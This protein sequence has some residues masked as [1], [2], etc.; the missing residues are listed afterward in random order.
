SAHAPLSFF[1]SKPRGGKSPRLTSSSLR[2]AG[3]SAPLTPSYPRC[4]PISGRKQ[5]PAKRETVTA[6][7]S[8]ARLNRY[9]ASREI[10]GSNETSQI[11]RVSGGGGICGGYY[12]SAGARTNSQG[13]QRSRRTQL[14]RQRRPERVFCSRQQRQLERVRRRYVSGDRRGHLQRCQQGRIRSSGRQPPIW[15]PSERRNRRPVTQ[16]H[17]DDVA[18]SRSRADLCGDELLRRPG[19]PHSQVHEQGN[20]A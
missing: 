19:L 9:D 15:S 14:R 7:P 2:K 18:G 4:S 11:F 8:I 10:R 1:A 3:T 5:K 12:C 20:R 13:R 16:H 6:S 17:V